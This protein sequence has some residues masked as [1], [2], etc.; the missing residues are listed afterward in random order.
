[1]QSRGR[2]PE[3]GE[4]TGKGQ[5]LLT[6]ESSSLP[7]TNQLARQTKSVDQKKD[8]TWKEKNS[9]TEP[10][11]DGAVPVPVENSQGRVVLGIR[12]G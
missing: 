8:K 7:G 2:S 4:Q 6:P 12:L 10:G 5:W 3:S 1:M 9:L 11:A